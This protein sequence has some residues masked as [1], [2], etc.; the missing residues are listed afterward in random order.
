MS[1]IDKALFHKVTNNSGVSTL[2]STRFYPVNLPQ[3]ATFPL[4]VYQSVSGDSIHTHGAPTVLPKPRYQ[5]TCW[6]LT[7]AEVVAIDKAIKNAID[8]KRESWGTGSYVTEVQECTSQS[9]P[10]HDRDEVTGIYTLSRDYFI[11]YK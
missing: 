10:R 11:R 9:E 4:A 8:G 6:A 2:I 5:I 7:F 1:D 3:T